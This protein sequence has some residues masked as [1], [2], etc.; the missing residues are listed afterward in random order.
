MSRY[1]V[2]DTHFAQKPRTNPEPPVFLV[3]YPWGRGTMSSAGELNA[4]DSPLRACLCQHFPWQGKE[5]KN[6]H[7]QRPEHL[8]RHLNRHKH[9][10]APQK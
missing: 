1:H 9:T 4:G 8:L 10:F 6:C 5:E 2:H 7:S 3:Q